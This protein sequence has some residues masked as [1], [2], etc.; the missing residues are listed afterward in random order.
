MG[1]LD[2][3]TKLELTMGKASSVDNQYIY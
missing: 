1:V 2:K 3:L